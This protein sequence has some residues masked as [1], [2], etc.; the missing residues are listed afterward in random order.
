M[1][2]L[3]SLGRALEQKVREARMVY[4]FPKARQ[5]REKWRNDD[6]AEGNGQHTVLLDIRSSIVDGEGGRRFHAL[7]SLLLAAD[8]RI[9]IKPHLRFFQS[10]HK[11]YKRQVMQKIEEDGELSPHRYDLCLSDRYSCHPRAD[12]TLRITTAT[13]RNIRANEIPFPYGMHPDVY[14][15]GQGFELKPYREQQRIWKLF[16]GGHRSQDAYRKK[17]Y[18]GHLPTT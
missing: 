17:S 12:K 18:Y 4:R 13:L 14:Q 3:L 8:C 10:F 11:C 5:A 16:F 1:S 7:V 2:K 9:W 15:S 6:R